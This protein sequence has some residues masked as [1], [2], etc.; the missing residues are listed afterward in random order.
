MF[1][2]VFLFGYWTILQT[3]KCADFL[4][5]FR[6]K[7]REKKYE[8][9]LQRVAN[10]EEKVIDISLDDIQSYHS[11][12]P[13][14]LQ[15]IEENSLRYISLFSN[16]IDGDNMPK[17][18]PNKDLPW[19]VYDILSDTRHVEINKQTNICVSLLS[20]K[21]VLLIFRF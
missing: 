9:L 11:N 12:D 13:T 16:A 17:P 7:R 14:F 4:R 5:N 8:L 2:N 21:C 10:R 19:D 6:T 18:D 1:H 15:H 20:D 3:E